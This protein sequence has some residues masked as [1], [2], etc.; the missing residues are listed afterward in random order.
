MLWKI[1]CPSKAL[2]LSIIKSKNP[3]KQTKGNPQV[4]LQSPCVLK[5]KQRR[6]HVGQGGSQQRCG[7]A[8]EG[9]PMLHTGTYI[10]IV[11]SSASNPPSVSDPVRGLY[12]VLASPWLQLLAVS[13][14]TPAEFAPPANKGLTVR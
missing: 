4:R 1:V 7:V 6:T 13:A 3:V 14:T 12:R 5:F 8:E 10:S 9:A 2:S 11:V